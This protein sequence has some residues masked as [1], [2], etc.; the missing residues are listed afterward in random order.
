MQAKAS[1][2]IS[3]EKQWQRFTCPDAW[4]RH[5][6]AAAKWQDAKNCQP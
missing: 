2:S 4:E 3:Y 6:A 1:A 5:F